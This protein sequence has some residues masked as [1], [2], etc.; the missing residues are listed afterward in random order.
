MPVNDEKIRK[1]LY[2]LVGIMV[3]I[4]VIAIIILVVIYVALFTP[5]KSS[6]VVITPPNIVTPTPAPLYYNSSFLND[7][8]PSSM[9]PGQTYTVTII[10]HNT[11]DTLW[12]NNS[13][14]ISQI[15]NSSLDSTIFCE[16]STMAPGTNIY[17]NDNYTWT[18]TMTA[19]TWNGNYTIAFQMS[20][21]GTWFGDIL[22]KNITVGTPGANVAFTLIDI[23]STMAVNNK[24]NITVIVQNM[25]RYPWYENNSV[26]SAMDSVQLG[27]SFLPDDGSIFTRTTQLHMNPDSGVMPGQTCKWVYP[28]TAPSY[29][30]QYNVTFQM[31]EGNEYFGAPVTKEVMITG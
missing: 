26:P 12:S 19:P 18:F 8:I 24:V 11:G 16:Q 14:F 30:T 10:A 29:I 21:N 31:M 13:T 2:I 17:K 6:P 20:N 23:P 27:I 1:E 5:H 7:T 22:V 3:A 25:G 28:I 9:S 15:V 4:I